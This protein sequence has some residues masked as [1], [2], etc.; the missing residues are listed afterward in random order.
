MGLF[1]KKQKNNKKFKIDKEEMKE[2]LTWNGPDGCIATNRITKEG[3]KVGYMYREK[4][5][6]EFDS[7]WRFFEGTETEE[8]LNNADNLDIYK[9]NTICNYD[10]DIIPYLQ[11]PYGSRFVKEK[12]GKFIKE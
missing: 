4:P 1:K 10:K 8:Y 2:L 9:L 7:G 12:D 3:K 5:K 11:E 6:N